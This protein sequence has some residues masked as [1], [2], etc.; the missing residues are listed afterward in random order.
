M[1][2]YNEP[3]S[4]ERDRK[5]ERMRKRWRRIGLTRSNAIPF[6]RVHTFEPIVFMTSTCRPALP[7]ALQRMIDAFGCLLRFN[8]FFFVV[9]FKTASNAQS[10]HVKNAGASLDP[11]SGQKFPNNRMPIQCRHKRFA[12]ITT[13]MK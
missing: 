10:Y 6:I 13:T 11:N 8:C 5:R 9:L 1:G 2:E 4:E 12:T 7:N 3:R